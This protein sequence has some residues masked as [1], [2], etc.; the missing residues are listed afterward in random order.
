MAMANTRSEIIREIVKDYL[1]QLKQQPGYVPDPPMIQADIVA[2][3]NRNIEIENN[4]KPSGQKWRFMDQL[5]P[6]IVAEILCQL[7]PIINLSFNDEA[8]TREYAALAIYQA[9][10]PET[11]VYT[12]DPNPLYTLIRAYNY[13]F[14]KKDVEDCMYHL[15]M[16]APLRY[17]N[18]AR[19]LIAVNNGIFDYD[20]KTLHGFSPDLV[21]TSKC[22]VDYVPNAVNPVIT[23]P[24]DGTTWDIETWM[25]E[26]FDDLSLTDL[27]W[28]IIGA[29][30]RPNVQWN[31]CAW[32]YSTTGENGKG[33]LCELMRQLAGPGT[34]ASIPISNF[35]KDFL[36][37]PLLRASSIICDEN[38]VGIF[39]DKSA[40]LKAVITN[41]PI[42]MNR[43][44]LTPLTFKFKGFMVQCLNE[45]P[46]VKDRSDSFTRR[47]LII[48]FAKCFTGAARKY[49][50]ED[51]V[52]RKDVLE[53][54]LYR[55]L[56]M[57]Y[58]KLDEPV[59]CILAMNEY[60]EYNDPVRQFAAEVLPL[61]QWDLVPYTFLYDLF[62]AWFKQTTPAG[63]LI[64]R[65]K[66]ISDL[67]M[68]I[69]DSDE[70]TVPP[71]NLPVRPSNRMSKPEPLIKTYNLTAWMN[72]AYTGGKD[73]IRLVPNPLKQSYKGLVRNNA[74]TDATDQ[75]AVQ[76]ADAGTT[77]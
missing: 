76:D 51:Y 6:E 23:N 28:Q 43:K 47:F 2:L 48:R 14:R 75:A 21:F 45:L 22:Q 65:N 62:T 67:Q 41:D 53:Y 54:V 16:M 42:Q 58:Y 32:F 69:L 25:N 18:S 24:Q 1:E 70:W 7:Y 40:N 61:C 60:K 59:S 46:R 49:I 56:H 20:T 57:N 68:V 33:T 26:L 52:R 10:G 13:Q 19:N 31:K 64:G 4:Q 39:V 15:K 17:R 50:K 36:L 29:N 8:R 38:D 34:Y 55:V 71:G 27:A 11:G 35:S 5:G 72:Q 77:A 9:E 66:F 37:E 30:I 3:V 74:G 44:H 63:T 12:T 73:E